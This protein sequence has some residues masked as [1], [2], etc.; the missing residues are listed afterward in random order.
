MSS[1]FPTR[2][3]MLWLLKVTW[4]ARESESVQKTVHCIVADWLEERGYQREAELLRGP[5]WVML[6]HGQTTSYKIVGIEDRPARWSAYP[7]FWWPIALSP[8]VADR[9]TDSRGRPQGPLPDGTQI[10]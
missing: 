8:E 1:A 4:L 2:N 6:F 9:Y 3:E 7:V 5:A 10:E